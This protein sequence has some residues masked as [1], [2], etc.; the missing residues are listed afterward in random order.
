[1]VNTTIAIS[2]EVYVDLQNIKHEL[3]KKYKCSLSYGNVIK[4]M[5]EKY[6]GG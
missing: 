3:E 1:M 4:H 5:V 2:K 6:R